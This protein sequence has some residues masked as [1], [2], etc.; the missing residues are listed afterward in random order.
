SIKWVQFIF[1]QRRDVVGADL[2]RPSPI[3]RPVPV[4]DKS[5][6]G[7]IN[8]PLHSVHTPWMVLICCNECSFQLHF[9]MKHF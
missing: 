8:R 4:A 3:Y 7:A 6:M 2:S 5:A 9:D 1:V